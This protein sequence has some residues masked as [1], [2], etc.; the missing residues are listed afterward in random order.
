MQKLKYLSSFIFFSGFVSIAA[1]AS[2][3]SSNNADINNECMNDK[4]G[5]DCRVDK[6]IVDTATEMRKVREAQ[7]ALN[8][9]GYIVEVDGV[10]DRETRLAIR[11]FQAQHNTEPNGELDAATMAL[12]RFGEPNQLGR[13]PASIKAD[14]K[15]KK[16]KKSKPNKAYEKQKEA[17]EAMPKNGHLRH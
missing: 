15:N 14:N 10:M 8:S 6:N 4:Y 17:L 13:S 2:P 12:L 1:Y 11:K 3:E 5:M 7:R 16:S 9:F